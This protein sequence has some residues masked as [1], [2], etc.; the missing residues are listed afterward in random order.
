MFFVGALFLNKGASLYKST[1]CLCQVWKYGSTL[2]LPSSP[3]SQFLM[4]V[5]LG[6]YGNNQHYGWKIK[7]GMK[8][9]VGDCSPLL[10]VW[11]VGR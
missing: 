10:Y 4:K 9:S 7:N 2:P 11:E 5:H 3:P 1:G 8:S 6:N